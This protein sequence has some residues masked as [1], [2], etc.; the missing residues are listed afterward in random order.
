MT[1]LIVTNLYLL[2]VG[3]V[4]Y[5]FAR[6]QYILTGVLALLPVLTISTC[7]FLAVYQPLVMHGMP[8]FVSLAHRVLFICAPVLVDLWIVWSRRHFGLMSMLASALAILWLSLLVAVF[9]TMAIMFTLLPIPRSSLGDWKN[10]QNVASVAAVHRVFTVAFG[11]LCVV[12]ASGGYLVHFAHVV[13][14]CV[15]QQLGGAK[16]VTVK[17][18]LKA[19][20]TALAQVLR[21]TAATSGRQITANVELVAETSEYVVIRIDRDSVIR[22]DRN[23]IEGILPVVTSAPVSH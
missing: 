13:L 7:W 14:P 3:I 15:P 2:R 12:L 6:A 4:E 22:V 10:A 19:G 5:S 11:V 16:P 9:L 8:K 21:T 23:Q 17:L 18:L 1:G 20:S